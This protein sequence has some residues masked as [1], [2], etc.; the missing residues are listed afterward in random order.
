VDRYSPGSPALADRI[1]LHID[2]PAVPYRQLS[3]DRSGESSEVIRARW[4]TRAS[5][6]WN[7]RGSSG[8]FRECAHGAAGFAP[9]L[10]RVRSSGCL[11]K[12][13]IAKLGL[14]AR[15]YHRV[16]KIARTI[17]DLAGTAEIAPAT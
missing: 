10:P 15:A 7:A 12:T 16:L 1:D 14:S 4:T 6:S 17:A 11:L 13:A 5:V 3:C 9:L 2:V 8:D